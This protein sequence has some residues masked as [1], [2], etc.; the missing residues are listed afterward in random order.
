MDVGKT[1]WKLV[2]LVMPGD[3]GRSPRRPYQI[4]TTEFDRIVRSHALD[5]VLGPGAADPLLNGEAVWRACL[6]KS[7]A[8]ESEAAVVCQRLRDGLAGRPT[9]VTLLVDQSG[10]MRNRPMERT[11]AAIRLAHRALLEAGCNVEVLGFTTASWKGGK[12]RIKWMSRGKPRRPGR[13]CDLLHVIYSAAG[14]AA[15]DERLRPMVRPDLLH[16]NV[17]GEALQWAASRLRALP[18]T[19]KLLVVL[20]DGASVDDAT[21]FHNYPE[22]LEDHLLEVIAEIY[23][24]ADIRLAGFGV[25]FDVGRYYA[26]SV[27]ADDLDRLGPELLEFVESALS[28]TIAQSA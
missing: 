27:I 13:L 15:D 6:A 20:S 8:W 16:E 4:F 10:S 18:E 17:D 7:Q 3:P 9:A 5:D 24:A 28:P 12:S 23:A 25:G 11:T 14:E 21:L 2:D 26:R 19:R 1:I 22:I